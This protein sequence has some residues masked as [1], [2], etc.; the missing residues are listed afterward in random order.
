MIG[1]MI[2]RL[3][4]LL[5][6]LWAGAL[7]T[8]CAVVAPLLFAWL[9]DRATAGR[10]AGSYFALIA[11]V[12]VPLALVIWGMSRRSASLRARLSTGWLAAV[13]VPPVIAVLLVRAVAGRAMGLGE[14]VPFAVAHSLASVLF[15]CACLSSLVLAWKINRPVG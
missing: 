9:E 1:V 6:A 7:W 2:Q 13:A 5:A 10:V 12:G 3:A 4:G 8:M 15:F 11:S 14:A